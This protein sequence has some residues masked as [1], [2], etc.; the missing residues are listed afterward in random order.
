MGTS[1][2]GV[3]LSD[4]VVV[5]S[6]YTRNNINFS[7]SEDTAREGTPYRSGIFDC[8]CRPQGFFLLDYTTGRR[9]IVYLIG[10]IYYRL[11]AKRAVFCVM[12]TSEVPRKI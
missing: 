7:I 9:F 1:S 2:R 8:A 10:I 3:T 11:N 4:F 5:R 6:L 12:F